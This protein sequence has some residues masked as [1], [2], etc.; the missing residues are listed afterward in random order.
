M[1]NWMT[2]VLWALAALVALA[3]ASDVSGTWRF[4]VQTEAG[5]GNPTFVFKQEGEKLTGTYSGLFGE[6]EVSGWVKGDRIEFEFTVS[7]EGQSIRCR[8]SGRIESPT[9]MKG[10]VEFG[11]VGSGSWTAV[12]K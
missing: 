12:K 3:E 11:N 4:T 2:R 8:Y 6:A 7:Y 5:A 1:L 9:Q 10:T